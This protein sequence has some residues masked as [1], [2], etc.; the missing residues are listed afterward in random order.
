MA[1]SDDTRDQDG[2][3]KSEQ[4]PDLMNRSVL[5]AMTLL[6]ELGNH[7]DGATAAELAAATR[8]PRPTS[9]RILLS[10][11]HA[12]MLVNSDGRF[13]LSWEFARLG[14]I[15]D[16]TKKLRPLAQIFV[17]RLANELGEAVA[18]SM[19]SD[20]TTM[21]L[22]AE[23]AGS[24]MLS[25]AMGY[26]DR[27]MPLHASAMGKVLLA[28]LS[29]EEVS[30]LLPEQLHSYTPFTITDRAVLLRELAD[31]RRKDYATL[32]NELEI[33]LFAVAI[34]LRDSSDALIGILSVSGL[35]Q[36]MKATNVHT[37]ID[38]LRTAAE[39][40]RVKVLGL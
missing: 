19:V 20:H 30:T 9:Y 7:P 26:V 22:I 36:R 35:D 13:S 34:P 24:Y 33:G 14:R 37:F 31:I 27:D 18:Y 25:T 16:P 40:F 15:A 10:M 23:A 6:K 5:R 28:S 11:T 39:Q 1:T 2:E 8:L 17:D 4:V 3:E 32:D 29:D 21:N 38:K 12:G